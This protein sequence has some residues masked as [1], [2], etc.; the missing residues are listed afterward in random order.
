MAPGLAVGQFM[1][2]LMV[3]FMHSRP[4]LLG[5]VFGKRLGQGLLL[6]RA[7]QPIGHGKKHV[8]LFINVSP[9]QGAVGFQVG[10]Q[11]RDGLGVPG[12]G[13]G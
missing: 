11:R 1:G 9:Q 13:L 10:C 6:D 5:L 7:E 12:P 4:D 2:Q 3:F 8:I